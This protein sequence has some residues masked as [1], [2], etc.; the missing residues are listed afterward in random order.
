[1]GRVMYKYFPYPANL[2]TTI[3]GSKCNLAIYDENM[4]FD[5]IK[6]F[7]A[8]EQEI[9]SYRFEKG[10][11]YKEIGEEL[12]ISDMRASQLVHRCLHFIKIRY[13]CHIVDNRV[14]I[15][16]LDLSTKCT[17][18]LKKSGINTVYDLMGYNKK[19]LYDVKG[20]GESTFKEIVHALNMQGINTRRFR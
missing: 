17:N 14:G 5:I 4:I 11:T 10:M 16:N 20:V 7:D 3:F 1:M 2:I 6:Q 18:N 8:R 9:I 19:S 15:E 13:A 12:G